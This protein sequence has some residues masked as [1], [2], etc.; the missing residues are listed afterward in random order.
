DQERRR[1]C[2]LSAPVSHLLPHPEIK[3]GSLGESGT[4]QT[5]QTCL[6]PFFFSR[7]LLPSFSLKFIDVSADSGGGAFSLHPWSRSNEESGGCFWKGRKTGSWIPSGRSLLHLCSYSPATP[8]SNR[9]CC[10]TD[11]NA[12]IAELQLSSHNPVCQRQLDLRAVQ[13]H[14]EVPGLTWSRR[15]WRPVLYEEFSFSPSPL[16][17]G[18]SS[19]ADQLWED[20]ETM[21]MAFLSPGTKCY[22]SS[23]A[24]G[25]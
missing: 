5:C 19:L 13:E 3:L 14:A 6:H 8:S 16:G 24:G 17:A 4:V 7:F 18:Q 25:M 11:I 15:M 2:T 1:F 22:L 20:L 9:L 21:G 10:M 23:G 12:L